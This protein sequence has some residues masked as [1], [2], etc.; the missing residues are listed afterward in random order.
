M[1]YEFKMIQLPQ[2]FV[3]KQDTGKEIAAYLENLS[4]QMGSQGWEF[5]RVDTVGVATN[6]GC[7]AALM[8]AKSTMSNYNIVT[9]RRAKA[10]P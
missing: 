3:L 5:Y 10:T 7:L 6:P 4:I 1:N 2:T 9:F 8:G